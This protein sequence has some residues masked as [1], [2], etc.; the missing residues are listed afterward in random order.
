[1]SGCHDDRDLNLAAHHE[2]MDETANDSL[3]L[4]LINRGSILRVFEEVH[5]VG[6]RESVQ[7]VAR[8]LRT[9]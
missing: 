7:Q 5:G 2:E 8:I 1:M 9:A 6:W 4:L 3:I